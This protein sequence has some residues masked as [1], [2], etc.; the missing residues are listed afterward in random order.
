MAVALVEG[1]VDLIGETQCLIAVDEAADEHR[2]VAHDARAQQT[3]GEVARGDVGEAGDFGKLRRVGLGVGRVAA[4]G[5]L[6]QLDAGQVAQAQQPVLLV[7]VA[8]L[9]SRGGEALDL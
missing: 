9:P 1:A 2:A 3:R 6:D 4:L 5:V 7:A 8:V